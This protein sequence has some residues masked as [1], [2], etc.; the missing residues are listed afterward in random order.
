MVS[1][2]PRLEIGVKIPAQTSK[3][4]IISFFFFVSTKWNALS[5]KETKTFQQRYQAV[6][7]LQLVSSMLG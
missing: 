1:L 5:C 4:R 2:K 7:C 6:T 3:L